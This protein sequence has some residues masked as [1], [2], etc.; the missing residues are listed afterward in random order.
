MSQPS[1]LS[2][3]VDTLLV[4]DGEKKM[5]YEKLSDLPGAVQKLPEKRQRQWMA[6]FNSAYIKCTAEG[7]E[8]SV[9]ET[10]SFAQAYGVVKKSLSEEDKIPGLTKDSEDLVEEYEKTMASITKSDV[11]VDTLIKFVGGLEK[12][13]IYGVV[14]APNEVD[15]DGDFADAEEIECAAH[16]FLPDAVMNL[17]H[18][19][20]L[21]DVQVVESYIAPCDFKMGEQVV[22]KG[23]WVLVTKVCNEDLKK[24]IASGE[25]TGYSLEGSATRIDYG[26]Q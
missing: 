2:A 17:H 11:K 20:N 8:T 6:V 19:D 1:N 15:T 21:E 25:I 7:G 14:Y 10:S 3:H 24:A 22:T 9:C 13:L 5:P 18:K 4:E 23:S 26:Q 16:N 12:G